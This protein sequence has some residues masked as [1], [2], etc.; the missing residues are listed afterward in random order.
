MLEIVPFDSLL[1]RKTL[2]LNP[3]LKESSE[4][5]GGA[6]LDLIAGN[7]LVDFKV[8]KVSE[9][10]AK[11]LDQLLGYYLL[12]RRHRQH[13]PT[14][15]E[16]RRV[17]LYFCRHGLLWPLDVTVW[18]SHPDFPKLEEWF[19][20][21][22]GEVFNKQIERKERLLEQPKGAVKRGKQV[23]RTSGPGDRSGRR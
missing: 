11:Y 16:I 8:S 3:T 20:K 17:A 19:F 7:L 13:H 15:P 22:A 14:F 4:L 10:Y 5:V 23:G 12:V 2:F 21:R 1:H 18:T 9:M 6:D